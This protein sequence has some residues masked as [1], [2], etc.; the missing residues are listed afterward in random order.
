MKLSLSLTVLMS[1][2]TLTTN[3]VAKEKPAELKSKTSDTAR[4]YLGAE[5]FNGYGISLGQQWAKKIALEATFEKSETFSFF[6]SC[7]IDDELIHNDL[8][9]VFSS[10]FFWGGSFNLKTGLYLRSL[11]EYCSSQDSQVE[12]SI[13]AQISIG[14]RWNFERLFIGGDWIGAGLGSEIGAKDGNGS[15]GRFLGPRFTIGFFL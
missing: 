13:G 4:W 3:A 6:S 15:T 2:P 5:L 9:A 12:R 10:R 7:A 14:N 8:T 11:E 1:I